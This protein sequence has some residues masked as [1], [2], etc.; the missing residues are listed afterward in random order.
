MLKSFGLTDVL[1]TR[2]AVLCIERLKAATTERPAILHD[3]PLP[4]QNG[5]ALETGKVVHVP[6]AALC[7]CALVSKDDLGG[8]R[9]S[10]DRGRWQSL[11]FTN[12]GKKT[13]SS[14]RSLTPVALVCY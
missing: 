11:Y 9:V 10:L 13:V 8:R 14:L 3:V 6:V 7:L 1:S 12:V 4:T 5:L 2:F